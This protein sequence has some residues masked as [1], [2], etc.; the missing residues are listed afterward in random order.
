MF[1]F[2]VFFLFINCVSHDIEKYKWW[3]GS[4]ITWESQIGFEDKYGFFMKVFDGD[5]VMTY[6]NEYSGKYSQ[7][8]FSPKQWG[9]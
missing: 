3:S 6:P 1:I 2:F 5:D 8:I 9:E 7:K 4:R